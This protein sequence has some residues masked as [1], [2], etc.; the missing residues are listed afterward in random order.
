MSQLTGPCWSIGF[1]H[2]VFPESSG[3]DRGKWTVRARR[4]VVLKW[5][6]AERFVVVRLNLLT[7]E[8]KI[9]SVSAKNREQN[10]DALILNQIVSVPLRKKQ[11]KWSDYFGIGSKL[12]VKYR[13][14]KYLQHS[15]ACSCKR[16]TSTAWENSA[17]LICC[18]FLAHC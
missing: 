3:V 10:E 4:S 13:R 2:C 15:C 1:S 12:Q 8:K 16:S 7:S 18:F 5:K 9:P 14:T 11:Y 6:F 17:R